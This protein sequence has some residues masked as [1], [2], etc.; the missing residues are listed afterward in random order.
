MPTS[1][2]AQS[3]IPK[4]GQRFSERIML[5]QSAL[6]RPGR[7]H[8][9]L[10]LEFRSR[11]PRY[12]DQGRSEAVS[13]HVAGAHGAVDRKIG[14]IGHEAVEPNDIRKRHARFGKDRPEA[15]KTEDAL[16]FN[17]V[18]DGVVGSDPELPGGHEQL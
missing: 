17:V 4:S 8:L 15:L 18:R 16:R 1:E 13:L 3:M 7:R 5:Q 11:E 14:A 6:D 2:A 12:D 10:D 9:D